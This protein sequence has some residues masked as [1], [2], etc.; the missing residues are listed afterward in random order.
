MDEELTWEDLEDLA[1]QL[2]LYYEEERM[3]EYESKKE[4]EE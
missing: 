3:K 4:E 1:Y 2:N